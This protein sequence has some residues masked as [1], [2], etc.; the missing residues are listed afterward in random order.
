M[1]KLDLFHLY[2][3]HWGGVKSC[4]EDCEDIKRGYVMDGISVVGCQLAKTRPR[5]KHSH[6][7]MVMARWG[8]S[9]GV[10]AKSSNPKPYSNLTFLDKKKLQRRKGGDSTAHQQSHKYLK[11]A[12]GQLTLQW[13]PHQR[14]CTL[15]FWLL[16]DPI[17][18]IY[19]KKKLCAKVFK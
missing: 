14:N 1:A 10:C 3:K 2:V 4:L 6:R 18:N 11:G 17:K 15:D 13:H 9:Q 8:K 12:T 5:N 7:H 16:I 19:Y